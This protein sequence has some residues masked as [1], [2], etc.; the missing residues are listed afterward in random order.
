MGSVKLH[1]L[2]LLTGEEVVSHTLHI[3][4]GTG[5]TRALEGPVVEDLPWGRHVGPYRC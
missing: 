2:V 3:D 5:S 1:F 4:W